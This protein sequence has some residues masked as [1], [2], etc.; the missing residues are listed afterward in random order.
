MNPRFLHNQYLVNATFDVL[1][2]EQDVLRD[3]RFKAYLCNKHVQLKG[4]TL[5]LTLPDTQKKEFIPKGLLGLFHPHLHHDS[6]YMRIETW[7]LVTKD[8]WTKASKS[9]K[10]GLVLDN[11]QNRFYS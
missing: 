4:A 6:E 11:W 3:V 1:K 5:V 8:F 9:T 2:A 7:M 10:E